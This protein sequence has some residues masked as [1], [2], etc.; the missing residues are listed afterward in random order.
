MT[1]DD[2]EA[3]VPGCSIVA[4]FEHL[5]ADEPFPGVMRRRLD[6]T[7]ATLTSY[8]FQPRARFPVHRHAEEQLTL[9]DEGEVIL[10]VQDRTRQL[11]RGAWAVIPGGVEHG[12]TAGPDGARITAIVVPRRATGDAY[13]VVDGQDSRQ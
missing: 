11:S 8:R 13:E 12:I 7:G 2:R 6:A 3:N 9:V 10:R 1:L 5:P 4:S